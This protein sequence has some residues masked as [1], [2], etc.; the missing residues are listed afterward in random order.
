MKIDGYSKHTHSLTHI[1]D[2]RLHNHPPA[3][4]SPPPPTHTPKI[5]GKGG[6]KEDSAGIHALKIKGKKKEVTLIEKKKKKN[7]EAAIA[8]R[9]LDS[10]IHS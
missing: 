10:R 5:W 3:P 7:E 6:G 9:T 4:P 1:H 2:A 8:L